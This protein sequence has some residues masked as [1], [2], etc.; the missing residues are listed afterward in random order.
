[1][2]NP[3]N[4]KVKQI[5]YGIGGGD[6]RN[7]RMKMH[8]M[9]I[10]DLAREQFDCEIPRVAILPTAHHN[11]TN[12]RIGRGWMDFIE[13]KF[14]EL[15]C[16]TSHIWIGKQLGER[17]EDSDKDV[18]EKLSKADAV[19]V[20]GGDSRYLLDV[21]R[22]RNLLPLFEKAISAGTVM[23]GTSA[24]LIWL[25]KHC[26]S[27]SESFHKDDWNYIMLEGLGILPLAINVHDNAVV[28]EGIIDKRSR[29]EQFEERFKELGDVPGL[30]V[31]EMVGLEITDGK[32]RL[33]SADESIGAELLVNDNGTVRRGRLGP[34]MELDLFDAAG[35]K[36]FVLSEP[37]F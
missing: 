2:N 31:D 18:A 22:E 1:M 10:A 21:V 16:E 9:R 37:H 19:F 11:G 24:G 17:R 27:D 28:P 5:I 30:A 15:G 23:S 33:R 32:C 26:M 4:S 35:L 13:E 12:E 6:M 20:L 36:S 29:R 3:G 34:G 25:S 7:E 8:Y 14:E